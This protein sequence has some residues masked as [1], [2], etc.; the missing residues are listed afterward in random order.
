MLQSEL[1][2][3]RFTSTFAMKRMSPASATHTQICHSERS[4]ESLFQRNGAPRLPIGR[5]LQLHRRQ[6][7]IL[8]GNQQL[9][10]ESALARPASQRLFGT[11]TRDIGIVIVL[12]KVRQD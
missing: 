5:G 6:R 9:T 2:L 11:N 4:E 3:S 1:E 12:R 10:R 7:L 8:R